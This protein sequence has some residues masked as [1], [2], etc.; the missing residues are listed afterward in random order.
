MVVAT[1]L[2]GILST[3]IAVVPLLWAVTIER[4]V[5]RAQLHAFPEARPEAPAVPPRRVA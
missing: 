2:L 3:V 1:I 5:S 4:P